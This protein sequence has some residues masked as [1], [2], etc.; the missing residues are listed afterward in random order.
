MSQEKKVRRPKKHGAFAAMTMLMALLLVPVLLHTFTLGFFC[1]E[2]A[3]GPMPPKGVEN[4]IDLGQGDYTVTFSPLQEHLAGFEL[5]LANQPAGNTGSLLLYVY[6]EDGT[7]LDCVTVDLGRI[8]SNRWHKVKLHKELPMGPVYTLVLSAK[9]CGT[10]PWLQEAPAGCLAP[11]TLTGG[12]LLGYGYASAA[13]SWLVKA[14]VFF[15]LLLVWGFVASQLFWGQR[16]KRLVR[17]VCGCVLLGLVLASNYTLCYMDGEDAV[18]PGFDPPSQKLVVDAMNA[19][20]GGA[21][22]GPYGLGDYIDGSFRP[23]VSQIGL[24]GHVFQVLGQ[25]GGP[26][27]LGLLC[28]LAAAAVFMGLV[29]VLYQKYGVIMAGCFYV[30]FWLSP[31]VVNF[32]AHLYWL[33]FTWFLP[34]FA[35][36]VCVWKIDSRRA[37]ALCYGGAFAS[38]FIKCLCGYEYISAVMVGLV[39]FPLAELLGAWAEK[40]RQRARR[41]FF[42]VLFLGCCAL[43][44]VFA[45]LLIHAGVRGEGDFMAGARLIIQQDV[46]RRTNG[47]DMSQFDSVYWPSLNASAFETVGKYLRFD[48]QIITGLP[49]DLFPLLCVLPLMAFAWDWHKGRLSVRDA[50]LYG[51]SALGAVSWF[52]LAK[53]HSFIHTHLNFVLWYF[54]FVQVCFYVIVYK[55]AAWVRLGPQKR[56]KGKGT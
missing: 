53:S 44:G 24:Q 30:A 16:K 26:R 52:V 18:G 41:L 9:Y 28:A 23:Y 1:D 13:Y 45:A 43:G 51:V 29:L 38:I 8:E 15:L 5:A 20:A 21:A 31:W 19:Y 27:V 39:L 2:T 49:G 11:E 40:D 35:G 10:Y 36:L 54:G 4:Y 33:E 50:S 55:L 47:G 46:L 32:A 3:Y 34:M 25:L 42:A 14:G 7:P 48:T 12:V 22:Q 56:R 6:G 37:R 17:Q